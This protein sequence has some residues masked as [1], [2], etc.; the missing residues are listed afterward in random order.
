MRSCAR[1]PARVY[2]CGLAGVGKGWSKPS[3]HA[4][5]RSSRRVCDR[6]KPNCCGS[7]RWNHRSRHGGS[8]PSALRGL[9]IWICLG[10]A[11][12]RC[13]H[14]MVGWFAWAALVDDAGI[15]WLVGPLGQRWWTMRHP[16]V[17]WS[18]WAA[19]V[20]DAASDGWLARPTTLVD[21]ADP[22]VGWSAWAALVDDAASDGWLRDIAGGPCGIRR[23]TIPE[24][25]KIR[26]VGAAERGTRRFPGFQDHYSIRKC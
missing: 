19:L 23:S 9:L 10:D 26:R 25:R 24:P 1:C 20:D 11:G 2:N 15:R 16:M 12:G 22:M 6:R 5:T 14:P 8:E 3:G 21:D 18:A 4:A 17:G 13:L 7:A